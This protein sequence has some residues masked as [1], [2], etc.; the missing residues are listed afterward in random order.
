MYPEKPDTT[1]QKTIAAFIVIL[2]VVMVTVGAKA[3]GRHQET[4]AVSSTPVSTPHAET[5]APSVAPGSNV[6]APSPTA[7]AYKDGTY[8][9]SAEYYVPHSAEQIDVTVTIKD[10]VVA[11]SSVQNSESNPESAQFQQDFAAQYKT[12]VVGKSIRGLKLG[13]VAGASDTSQGFN[14]ALQQIASKAAA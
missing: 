3:Y 10:G 6:P 8:T 5:T 14:E 13:G 4:P 7:T 9:A 12:Y 11:S 1:K 2:A